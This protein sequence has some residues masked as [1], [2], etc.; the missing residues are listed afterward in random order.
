MKVK[1]I[2]SQKGES[3]FRRAEKL[4]LAKVLLQGRAGNRNR[5]WR[6]DG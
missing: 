5:R 4:A 6:R 3:Y 1:E 2:F